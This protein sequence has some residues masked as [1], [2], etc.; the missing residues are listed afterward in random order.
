M[1]TL[2]QLRAPQSQDGYAVNQLVARCKPLDTNSLYCNLLQCSHF[3]GTSVAAFLNDKLVGFISGYLV[4]ERNNTLF[5]WQ[6][7]VD[8][9]ARGLGLAGKMIF[10][11]LGR[12]SCKAVEFIETTITEDNP[13]SWAL[14]KGQARRLDTALE[15]SLFFDKVIHFNSEHESEM[16]VKIGPI[17][18][19]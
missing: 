7:A 14:F 1:D 15:H 5:I 9:S 18:A 2:V 12:E 11:L 10:N 8:E 6:V 16:L 13:A 17:A 4:P 19:R 3:S